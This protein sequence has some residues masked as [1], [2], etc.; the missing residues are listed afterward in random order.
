MLKK[1]FINV[2]LIALVGGLSSCSYISKFTQKKEEPKEVSYE[3]QE[4]VEPAPTE[5]VVHMHHHHGNAK[6]V[7][8]QHHERHHTEHHN[9]KRHLHSHALTTK[10]G[11]TSIEV[12]SGNELKDVTCTEVSYSSVSDKIQTLGYIP[13]STELPEAKPVIVKE[14][15]KKIHRKAK[16]HNARKVDAYNSSNK[17]QASTKKVVHAEEI[18][19][20]MTSES[21]P[22]V[23]QTTNSVAVT[24][25]PVAH[26]QVEK[27]IKVD[28]P[29]S[30]STSAPTPT[31]A[32]ANPV[33]SPAVVDSVPVPVAP[34]VPTPTPTP[35]P[36]P[37]VAP[38]KVEPSASAAPAAPMPMP[39][40][41]SLANSNNVVSVGRMATID[42]SDSSIDIP[43]EGATMLEQIAADLKQ[44]A[45]KNLKIQSYAFSKDG[46]ATEAR[47]NSLQ[48]AIKVRKYLI[49]KG[50]SASRISVNAIEDINNK[51]NKV[52][53]SFEESKQ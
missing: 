31:P 17:D 13:S 2:A 27:S 29:S 42:Y 23:D 1:F 14:Q 39:N 10:H 22:A 8:H 24:N 46:N 34:V 51:L 38:T 19:K 52:E 7:A 4:F 21:V 25:E 6:H 41:M 45:S 5:T 3:E 53:I 36:V 26:K 33:T 28:A 30:T 20:N 15:P 47:R 32:P 44:N 18:D 49:D 9:H 48:R 11:S 37:I 16:K 35:A 43:S 40:E 50:V 12:D